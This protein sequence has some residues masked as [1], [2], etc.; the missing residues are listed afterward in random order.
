MD[1]DALVSEICRRVQE[2]MESYETQEI[3]CGNSQC[4]EKPKLLILNSAHGTSC[5]ELLESP[6]LTEYYDTD[7]ALLKEYDCDMTCYEVVIAYDLSNESL[8]KIA[9]GIFDNGYTHLFGKALLSGKKIFLPEEEVELYQ[10]R[11]KSPKLYYQRLSANLKLLQDSGVVIA[12]NWEIQ[13]L[14]LTGRP[15][16]GES[17]ANCSGGLENRDVVQREMC[18]SKHIITEK[19]IAAARGEKAEI[20]KVEP[21]AILT[22]LAKEY[23]DKQKIMILRR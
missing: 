8:G 7:C 16:D 20:I 21:R 9:N 5:H 23:A 14:I 22:D 6:R 10:Y 12:P 11:K 13:N 18:I 2:R 4:Q 19:D 17:E 15:P 1:I 3:N